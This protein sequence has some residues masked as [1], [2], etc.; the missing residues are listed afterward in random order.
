MKCIAFF[1]NI[2]NVCHL[3]PHTNKPYLKYEAIRLLYIDHKKIPENTRF[4]LWS[5]P[6]VLHT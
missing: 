5:T 3:I 4:S 1:C 2:S 6:I